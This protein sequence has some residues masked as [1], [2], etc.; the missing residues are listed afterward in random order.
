MILAL[1]RDEARKGRPSEADRV[2]RRFGLVVRG[3]I[4]AA[5]ATCD[6]G[7]DW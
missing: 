3:K 6:L 5:K 2:E 1:S 4:R 7:D